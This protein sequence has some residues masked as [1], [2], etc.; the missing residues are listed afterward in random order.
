MGCGVVPGLEVDPGVV[1]IGTVPGVVP[2]EECDSK[3]TV[4]PGVDGGIVRG[5]RVGFGVVEGGVVG[6]GVVG[7]GVVPG[8]DAGVVA[9]CVVGLV[10]AGLLVSR[11]VA[12]G[13]VDE[14]VV[15]GR[16]VGRVVGGAVDGCS[17]E[18]W[19]AV[20]VPGTEVR[21]VDSEVGFCVLRTVDAVETG[22]LCGG[23]V[24][25]NVVGGGVG[26]VGVGVYSGLVVPGAD[27]VVSMGL[28]EAGAGEVV[29][30][31]EDVPVGEEVPVGVGVV[32]GIVGVAGVNAGDD[33]M[34]AVVGGGNVVRFTV[35]LDVAIG[36]VVLGA[37][38]VVIGVV[39]RGG[40]VGCTGEV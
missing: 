4:V 22:T 2:G 10:V 7:I 37:D 40:V 34:G 36:G 12:V 21:N 27:G 14:G 11:G 26:T 8:V 18:V 13:A 1:G 15:I 29:P 33:D 17:G 9:G 39:V 32:P 3:G 25:F 6:G 19:G 35:P 20:A 28:V 24:G 31:G 16:V 5:G 30:F 23:R 38:V